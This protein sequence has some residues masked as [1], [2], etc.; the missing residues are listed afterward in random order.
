MNRININ[1]EWYVKETDVYSFV[2]E[3]VNVLTDNKREYDYR[4]LT[5]KE[6]YNIWFKNNYETGMEY[7]FDP[8]NLPDFSNPHWDPTPTKILFKLK[9]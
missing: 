3:D 5:D 8:K 2:Y 4:L 9:T 7:F 1:G 6:R